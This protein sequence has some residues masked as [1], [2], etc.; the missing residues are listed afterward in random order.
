LLKAVKSK[1]LL[2]IASKDQTVI[3]YET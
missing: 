3:G 2:L 1:A